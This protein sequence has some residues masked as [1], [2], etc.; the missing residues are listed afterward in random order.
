MFGLTERSSRIANSFGAPRRTM[1]A[2]VM[3]WVKTMRGR[4]A[5]ARL[6][7]RLLQDIGISEAE[8]RREATRPFWQE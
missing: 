4:K 8:A 1:T 5:L 2:R 7:A 3:G 6:D